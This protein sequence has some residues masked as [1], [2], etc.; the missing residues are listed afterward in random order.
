MSL[1]SWLQSE[2][3]FMAIQ[4]II[5]S[6]NITNLMVAMEENS[7]TD[8]G[9]TLLETINI[10]TKLQVIVAIFQSGIRR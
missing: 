5:I 10:C 1:I 7:T 8:I 2:P 6:P 4:I 3:N 9:V